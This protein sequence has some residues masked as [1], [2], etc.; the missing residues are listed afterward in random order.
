MDIS[1]VEANRTAV[2]VGYR[3]Y[4]K[5]KKDHS[6]E[7]YNCQNATKTASKYYAVCYRMYDEGLHASCQC[8]EMMISIEN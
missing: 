2:T 8:N 3:N 5:R 4:R 1:I 6:W 7:W